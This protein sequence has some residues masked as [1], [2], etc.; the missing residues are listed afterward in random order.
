VTLFKIRELFASNLNVFSD[1]FCEKSKKSQ[2]LRMTSDAGLKPGATLMRRH[3]RDSAAGDRPPHPRQVTTLFALLLL[4]SSQAVA[5]KPVTSASLVVQLVDP[6]WDPLPGIPVTVKPLSEKAKP[7]VVYTDEAGYAKF[8]LASDRDY[9]IEA[10]WPGF[11]TK[12]VRVHLFD[13]TSASPTAYVQLRLKSSER[14][15]T[16][17]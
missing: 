1:G 15:I 14:P 4:M 11:K 8:W 10:K 9:S 3:Q 12:R 6:V 5:P 17:Y 16:V 13:R 7:S 2:P